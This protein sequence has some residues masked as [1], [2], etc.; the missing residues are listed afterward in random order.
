MGWTKNCVPWP[1][2]VD[3]ATECGLEGPCDCLPDT[4]SCAEETGTQNTLPTP[5]ANTNQPANTHTFDLHMQEAH[6]GSRNRI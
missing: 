4:K 5:G 3:G 6:S 2:F 1:Q